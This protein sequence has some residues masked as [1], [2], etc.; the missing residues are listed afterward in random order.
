MRGACVLCGRIGPV[1]SHHVTGRPARGAAY[2]D[3]LLVV[4][5]CA[6]TC[7]TGTGGVHQ[8]LRTLGLEWQP[9]GAHPISHRLR[10]GA[11]HRL[12]VAD[13]ERPFVLSASSA[14][15]EAALLTEAA[16]ALDVGGAS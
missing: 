8:V 10:R 15:A 3:P 11:V 13:A 2:S 9:E 7:H 4:D 1:Q 14:R 16:D 12:L 6:A 5:L